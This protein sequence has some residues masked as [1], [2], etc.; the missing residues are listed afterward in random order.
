[1]PDA[2]TGGRA[3]RDRAAGLR[4]RR[5][6]RCPG[7]LASGRL[8]RVGDERTTEAAAW[9]RS[10][11]AR[12]RCTSSLARLAGRPTPIPAQGRPR[13]NAELHPARPQRDLRG[14]LHDGQLDDIRQVRV[15]RRT[16]G[17]RMTSDDLVELADRATSTWR[18]PGLAAGSSWTRAARPAAA[19]HDPLTGRVHPLVAGASRPSV[20]GA[21]QRG[22]AAA[23]SPR[24]RGRRRAV[25][26]S[27][28]RAPVR[29]G[30]RPQRVEPVAAR[31]IRRPSGPGTGSA[32]SAAQPAVGRRPPSRRSR[33][34]RR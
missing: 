15:R 24:T 12:R 28:Q 11:S 9:R 1:M 33:P 22:A 2:V 16:S 5:N 30:Q 27:H 29:H 23:P 18:R 3:R 7:R 17:S 20:G 14:H 34:P 4:Y 10:P 6:A 19:A 32:C 25:A 21:V 31:R 8:A 26:R 13:Q